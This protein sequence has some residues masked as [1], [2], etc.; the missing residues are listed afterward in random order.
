MLL[1]ESYLHS[2]AQLLG[3]GIDAIRN[4]AVHF[5]V[6][7]AEFGKGQQV[8]TCEEHF[9]RTNDVLTSEAFSRDVVALSEVLQ[10]HERG[11]FKHL[12]VNI[13]ALVVGL[14]HPCQRGILSVVARFFPIVEQPTRPIVVSF[15]V[16]YMVIVLVK[17]LIHRNHVLA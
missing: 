15:A 14:A 2:H 8:A 7:A 12:R 1:L 3:V 10:T 9:R 5:G 17:L 11:V 13:V 6:D 4:I 16:T